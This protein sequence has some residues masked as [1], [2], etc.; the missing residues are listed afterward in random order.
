[1]RVFLWPGWAY[2]GGLPSKPKVTT[3]EIDPAV[4]NH[5]RAALHAVGLAVP[6][7]TGDGVHG[8]PDRA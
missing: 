2:L 8:Y 7:V 5:A 1:M 3:V 4:A 6:V